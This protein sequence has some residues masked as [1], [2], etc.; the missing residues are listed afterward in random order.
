MSGM[1]IPGN[2][3]R[4]YGNENWEFDEQWFHAPPYRKHQ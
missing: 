3:F 2:W 4:S 1:M